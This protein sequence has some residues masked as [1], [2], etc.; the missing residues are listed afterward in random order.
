ML[1]K[2]D[3]ALSYVVKCSWF[4][5]R[6]KLMKKLTCVLGLALA[7]TCFGL[8]ACDDQANS[9]SASSSETAS[10]STGS[11]ES[12]EVSSSE[13]SSSENSSSEHEHNFVYTTTKEATLFE[14]GSEKGVCE[15]DNAEDVRAIAAEGTTKDVI[16]YFTTYAEG[17]TAGEKRCNFRYQRRRW[18]RCFYLFQQED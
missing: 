16:K 11:S 8:V 14:P 5:E 4:Y 13:S 9:S 17:I 3:Q 10:S 2:F 7:A 15:A 1:H 6:R 12:S 18:L